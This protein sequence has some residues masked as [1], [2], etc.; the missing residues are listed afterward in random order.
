ML[1]DGGQEMILTVYWWRQIGAAAIFSA[2]ILSVC[3]A[4][5]PHPAVEAGPGP[6]VRVLDKTVSLRVTDRPLS[7]VAK[8]LADH[9]GR[10]IELHWHGFD[11]EPRLSLSV[12]KVAFWQAVAEVSIASKIPFRGMGGPIGGIDRQNGSFSDF[13]FRCEHYLASGPVL[14]LQRYEPKSEKKVDGPNA[15]LAV[16]GYE[17]EIRSQSLDVY[18]KDS[19][20]GNILSNRKGDAGAY[21]DQWFPLAA[22]DVGNVDFIGGTLRAKIVSPLLK[23]TIP[24]A[25]GRQAKGE[26]FVATV[27]KL[28]LTGDPSVEVLIV[29]DDGR[30]DFRITDA[31]LLDPLGA[32]EGPRAST[33]LYDATL[34]TRARLSATDLAR[35]SHV[36]VTFGMEKDVKVP[37][38]FPLPKK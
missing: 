20:S 38:E 27:V 15:V 14:I 18:L 19:K 30:V 28:D 7:E 6:I 34:K 4:S 35:R 2:G 10:R 32:S 1:L 12:D 13:G 3:R 22:A 31:W 17:G 26:G 16:M 9:S 25:I 24:L 23:A 37:F 36:V 21:D 8:D 33:Y 29:R 11:P 5:E